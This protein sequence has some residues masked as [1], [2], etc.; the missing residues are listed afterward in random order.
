MPRRVCWREANEALGHHKKIESTISGDHPLCSTHQTFNRRSDSLESMHRKESTHS[1]LLQ[2]S[3][4]Q[5]SLLGRMLRLSTISVTNTSDKSASFLNGMVTIR[6]PRRRGV[7]E[8]TKPRRSGVV[9]EMLCFKQQL[10]CVSSFL[11]PNQSSP[12]R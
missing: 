7:V 8:K 9:S 5:T 6:S 1:E 12:C 10:A 4:C 2:R 11:L 3:T